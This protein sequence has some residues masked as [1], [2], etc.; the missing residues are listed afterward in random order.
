MFFVVYIS[1]C[2][3]YGW[4]VEKAVH[5]SVPLICQFFGS[6]PLWLLSPEISLLKVFVNSTVG[7]CVTTQFNAIGTLLVDL[8]PTRSASATAANNLYRCLM[9]AAGT[10]VIN[11]I[12]DALGTGTSPSPCLSLSAVLLAVL[13]H[14]PYTPSAHLLREI[15]S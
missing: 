2:I 13:L 3:I 15:V 6:S 9:G 10:A 12:I 1:V 4:T 14:P 7:L 5:L 11:P 8:H